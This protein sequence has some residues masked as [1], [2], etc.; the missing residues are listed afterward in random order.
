MPPLVPLEAWRKLFTSAR[1]EIGILADAEFV[2][3]TCRVMSGPL[4]RQAMHGV[5]VRICFAGPVTDSPES[6][7]AAELVAAI[8]GAVKPGEVRA[9]PT[10]GYNQSAARTMTC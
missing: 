2:L 7:L 4:A 6:A 10:R 9:L 3:R 5:Q 8:L 1:R